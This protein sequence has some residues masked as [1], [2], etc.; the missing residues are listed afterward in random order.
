M[1][2]GLWLEWLMDCGTWTLGSS[3]CLLEGVIPS[4]RGIS[5]A[6][7]RVR[8]REIPRKLG[9]TEGAR[10]DIVRR[11]FPLKDRDRDW[12]EGSVQR[13]GTGIG[14]KIGTRIGTRI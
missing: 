2:D 3:E 11:G 7:E 8:M 6:G 14:A 4:L 9:M 13:I 5:L 10:D 1:V 12:A